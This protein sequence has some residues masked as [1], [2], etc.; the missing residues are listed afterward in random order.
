MQKRGQFY[1]SAAV[2][3]VALVAGIFFITN[4]SSKTKDNELSN[5]Q[6]ELNTEIE[7][8]T[9]YIISKNLDESQTKNVLINLSSVYINKTGTNKNSLFIFGTRSTIT[10]KGY[11]I[12][13]SGDFMLNYGSGLQNI[14]EFPGFFES[15]YGDVSANLT[16]K[17]RDNY[18]YYNITEWQS[19]YY[20]ISKD[21]GGERI[22]IR[23]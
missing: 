5:L 23:N 21:I 9:E 19:F 10:L 11:R 17:D 20:L 15:E 4:S 3:I 2:I 16:I 12:N 22:I 6:K 13:N 1:L 8:T 7:K 14:T 18:Y